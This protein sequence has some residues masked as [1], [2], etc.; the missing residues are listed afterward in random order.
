MGMTC[1]YNGLGYV[2]WHPTADS[3]AGTPPTEDMKTF[4][5]YGGYVGGE[6]Q[7]EDRSDRAWVLAS[8]V[9]YIGMDAENIDEELEAS[10]RDVR[11]TQN[12]VRGFNFNSTING[13]SLYDYYLE[14]S[15]S[16]TGTVTTDWNYY[17]YPNAYSTPGGDYINKSKVYT[18]V[19]STDFNV[20]SPTCAP[21]LDVVPAS[22]TPD[23]T[24]DYVGF[25]LPNLPINYDNAGFNDAFISQD[26]MRQNC[27][28]DFIAYCNLFNKTANFT[29]TYTITLTVSPYTSR[30]VTWSDSI[31]SGDF[32][33]EWYTEFPVKE[34]AKPIPGTDEYLSGRVL[35]YTFAE[36][37]D[38]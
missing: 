37:Y 30:T 36:R 17:S 29:V 13:G 12:A 11:A 26:N 25:K 6:L 8:I 20:G 3:T 16:V 19:T 35:T 34:N 31:S 23:A 32:R 5:S 38:Q 21:A 4:R 33:D 27:S 1:T 7:F 22:I 2:Y 14:T 28:G 18:N 15:P 24:K 10:D 9:V